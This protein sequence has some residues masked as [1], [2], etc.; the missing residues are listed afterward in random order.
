[1]KKLKKPNIYQIMVVM[2][3]IIIINA[4]VAAVVDII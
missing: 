4:I 2:E 3:W 1:M